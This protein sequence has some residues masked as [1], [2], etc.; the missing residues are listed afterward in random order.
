[1]PRKVYGC[2]GGPARERLGA[3]AAA[4]RGARGDRG[5]ARA[6]TGGATAPARTQPVDARE[7]DAASRA[8]ARNGSP[9]WRTNSNSIL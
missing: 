1:M 7:S 3:G 6:T 5:F 9:F 2:V 8:R 4:G